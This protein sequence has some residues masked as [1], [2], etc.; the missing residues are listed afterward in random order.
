[1]QLQ[2][3]MTRCIVQSRDISDSRKQINYHNVQIFYRKSCRS[4]IRFLITSIAAMSLI[5]GGFHFL[6]GVYLHVLIAIFEF[7]PRG[8]FKYP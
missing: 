8:L 3:C 6:N 4:R 2:N 1:M 7:R 5:Y